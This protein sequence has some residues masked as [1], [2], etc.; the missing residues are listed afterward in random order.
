MLKLQQ[1]A[2][3]GDMGYPAKVLVPPALEQVLSAPFDGVVD[4]LLVSGHETVKTG[5]PLLQLSSPEYGELQ[6]KLMG[7]PGTRRLTA[8][9]ARKSAPPRAAA[10]PRCVGP[11]L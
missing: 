3:I 7:R 10:L 11:S 8:P 5:Q 9:A 1:T 4:R 6:L 2:A